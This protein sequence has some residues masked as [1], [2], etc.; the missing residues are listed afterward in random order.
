MSR[1]G[2]YV[3][4]MQEAVDEC[5]WNGMRDIQE[6]ITHIRQEMGFVDEKFVTEYFLRHADELDTP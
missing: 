6:I 2:N 1:I 3:E 4:D 5:V